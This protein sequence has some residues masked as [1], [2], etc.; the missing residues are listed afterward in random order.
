[1]KTSHKPVSG[2]LSSGNSCTLP[3]ESGLVWWK[4]VCVSVSVCLPLVQGVAVAE[5]VTVIAALM[6]VV[7]CS[8]PCPLQGGKGGTDELV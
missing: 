8:G 4:S 3:E 7:D 6:H 2:R 1:M 5:G